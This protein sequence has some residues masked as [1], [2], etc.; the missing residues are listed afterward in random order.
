MI[1]RLPRAVAQI[2]NR[3]SRIV[4][5]KSPCRFWLDNRPRWIP[6]WS[7]A[8]TIQPPD[9]PQIVRTAGH[10]GIRSRAGSFFALR[11]ADVQLYRFCDDLSG[12]LIFPML[13]FGPWAFGTTEFWSVRVMNFAGYALGILLSVQPERRPEALAHL[14]A[15]LRIKPDFAPAREWI[16]RLQAARP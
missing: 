6:I 1:A 10:S 14:E 11:A 8:D 4:N 5:H 15:A 9:G 16:A 2:V 7:V 13:V 12:V 3:K